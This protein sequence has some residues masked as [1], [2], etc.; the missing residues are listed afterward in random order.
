MQTFPI[1]MDSVWLILEER[2]QDSCDQVTVLGGQI[3]SEEIESG[4]AVD[5]DF[6]IGLM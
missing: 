5:C 2:L 3:D 6:N 4:S 1:S